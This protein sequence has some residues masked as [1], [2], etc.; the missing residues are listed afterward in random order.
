VRR[1]ILEAARDCFERFGVARTRVEDVAAGAGLSRPLLYQYVDGRAG[2]IE[3]MINDELARLITVLRGRVPEGSFAD[4]LVE[5]SVASIDVGRQD[6]LLDDLFANSQYADVTTF[7]ERPGS[8]THR[9]MMDLWSPIFDRG[10]AEGVLRD[11]VDDEELVEWLMMSHN[12]LYQRRD[13]SLDR[14]AVMIRRFVV[15]SFTVRSAA[16]VMALPVDADSERGSRPPTTRRR[17][18]G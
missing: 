3:A 16:A 9:M 17:R 7:M 5:L 15:P 18:T 12:T 1:R 2:L 8:P 14:V 11:D 6:Q 10:R 13:L 4:A